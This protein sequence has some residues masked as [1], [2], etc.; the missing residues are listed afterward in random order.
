MNAVEFIKDNID[1]LQILNYYNFEKVSEHDSEIRSCCGIHGG[2]NP[3][4]FVWNK[5]NNLWYCYTGECGGGDVFD[6]VQRIENVDFKDAV[7][8]VASILE[9][10]IEGMSIRKN[11]ILSEQKKWLSKNE[12]IKLKCEELY[13]LPNF[14]PIDNTNE[15]DFLFQTLNKNFSQK[16]LSFYDSQFT[17]FFPTDNGLLKNKLVIPLVKEKSIKGVALRDS[18][19]IY[20]PKWLYQPTGIQ[21]KRIMY[22]W[23]RA[24]EV[25]DEMLVTEIILVEGIFDVW[26]YHEIGVDNV[27]AVMGSSLSDYQYQEILKLGVDVTLSFDNDKAG[28]KCRDKCIEKFKKKAD[29]KVIELPDGKDPGDLSRDELRTAYLKRHKI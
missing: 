28:N 12:K 21:T 14:K 5:K 24:V 20:Q 6:L 8:R 25:I 18:T 22:N 11:N 3:L 4:G 23:D 19:G 27:I 26:A 10:D 29:M 13:S 2:D 9:L 1:P 15:I 16:T 17:Q 7:K